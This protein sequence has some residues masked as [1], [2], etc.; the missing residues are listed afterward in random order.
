LRSVLSSLDGANLII[1][2]EEK[3]LERLVIKNHNHFRHEK[4]FKDV[5]VVLKCTRRLR[6]VH[7]RGVVAD[8]HSCLPLVVDVVKQHGSVLLPTLQM[9]HFAMLRLMGAFAIIQKLDLFCKQAALAQEQRMK[10]GHFW[11]AAVQFLAAG[12]RIWYDK[13]GIACPPRMK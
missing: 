10:T 12:S 11:N 3:L 7:V 1:N 2:T 6:E 9:L 8:L 13:F 4:S 5:K